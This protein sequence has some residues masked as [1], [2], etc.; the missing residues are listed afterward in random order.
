[1]VL[2]VPSFAVSSSLQDWEFNINGTDYYPSG[3]AT[4][5]SVPGLNSSGFNS[6]TGQGT[7]QVVFNPGAAGTYYVGA[8][9]FAPVSVPF[10]NEY[11]M[12]N[13]ST[14]ANQQY[15]VDIP[16]YDVTSPNHGAGT[17]LNNLATASLSGS[18][19]VP[20]TTDNYLNNCGA[21][22]GGAVNLS[23]NDFVS[24]ALGYKFTLT[25]NQEEVINFDLSPTNPGGFSVEDIHP[26][27]GANS[28][29]SDLF[30]SETWSTQ[31]SGSGPPPPP[32]PGTPEPASWSLAALAL[33]LLALLAR[34]RGLKP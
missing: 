5:G 34:K 26:V 32:P 17:V 13:G 24:L 20:G 8:W 22:G 11:G 14:A 3:G 30:L 12:V 29:A 6:T 33:P 27:D 23:C 16:E 7:L 10:Y 21:N 2:L 15:Q 19:S 25:A 1:M 18:N 4:L 31:P 28:T 9:F